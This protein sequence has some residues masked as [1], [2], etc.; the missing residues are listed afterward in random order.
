MRF[1]D[2]ADAGR[3]LA[4]LLA[5]L[6]G[7][8]AV[9]LGLPRGGVPVAREVAAALGA[10]LDVLVVRKLGVPFQPELAMGAVGEDAVQVI[11][12]DVVRAARISAA[13]LTAVLAREQAEV[14]RQAADYRRGRPRESL[15]GRI[16]V[17]VDDGIATGATARAACRAARALGAAGV[18]LAVPVA[19]AGWA[20]RIGTDADDCVAVDSPELF[21]AVGQF[22][23]DFS[24]TS[25][26]EVIAALAGAVPTPPASSDDT[27]ASGQPHDGPH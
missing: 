8:P 19:P 16:A 15:T 23:D 11:N 17:I 18:I 5:D 4:T 22:Y 7:Q 25:D 10:P 14:R 1:R 6:S 20:S 2:R 12:P 26:E 3:Q 9:V 27:A 24:P 13:E 21:D